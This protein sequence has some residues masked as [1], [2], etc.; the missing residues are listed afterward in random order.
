MDDEV[1]DDKGQQDC[2][3][4][5]AALKTIPDRAS[6]QIPQAEVTGGGH[7]RGSSE[8]AEV[9]QAPVRRAGGGGRSC[10]SRAPVRRAVH[11]APS[12]KSFRIGP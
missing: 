10:S 1:D 11:A 7:R 9:L 5:S 3:I 4:L 12:A 8:V 2:Q 6:A